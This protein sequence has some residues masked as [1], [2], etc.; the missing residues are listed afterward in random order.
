MHASSSSSSSSPA[1]TIETTGQFI[2]DFCVENIGDDVYLD[3]AKRD[4]WIREFASEGARRLS[5]L[6][7]MEYA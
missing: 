5:S 2:N 7:G 3:L 1:N 6:R 4:K